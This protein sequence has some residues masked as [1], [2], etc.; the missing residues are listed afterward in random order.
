MLGLG[1]WRLEQ[2]LTFQNVTNQTKRVLF[3]PHA[4]ITKCWFLFDSFF[5]Y[6]LSIQPLKTKVIGLNKWWYM[7][8]N[9]YTKKKKEV[10]GKIGP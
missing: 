4:K 7:H 8:S 2:G 6:V 1:A 3:I 5:F 9:I 10:K